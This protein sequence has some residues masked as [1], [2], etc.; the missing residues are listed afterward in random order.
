MC[1][2]MKEA[3]TGYKSHVQLATFYQLA[4]H[5]TCGQ[6]V[7]RLSCGFHICMCVHTYHVRNNYIMYIVTMRPYVSRL[8]QFRRVLCVAAMSSLL[9]LQLQDGY[10]EAEAM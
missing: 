10:R 2:R 4:A 6:L 1:R 3:T 5:F 9:Q 7:L 8:W